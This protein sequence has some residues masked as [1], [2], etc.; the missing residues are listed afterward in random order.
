MDGAI[1]AKSTEFTRSFGARTL[2]NSL[3]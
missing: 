3:R 1:G 2:L